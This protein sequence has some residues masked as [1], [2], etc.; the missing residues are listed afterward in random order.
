M[1]MNKGIS[2]ICVFVLFF[3]FTACKN[4]PA[5]GYTIVEGE[6]DEELYGRYLDIFE[7]DGIL[8]SIDN[9]DVAQEY[10]ILMDMS[11]YGMEYYSF[12]IY[13]D[14][15]GT[16]EYCY[17]QMNVEEV[18]N[19]ARGVFKIYNQCYEYLSPDE[20]AMLLDAIEKSGFRETEGNI[21]LYVEAM[22]GENLFVEG[23]DGARR[24]FV[25]QEQPEEDHSLKQLYLVFREFVFSIL[26]EPEE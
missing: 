24:Y 19:G 5:I 8:D 17:R 4:T 13:N 2:I 15:T 1:R 12:Q 23:N 11:T 10:R 22:D 7:V 25:Q 21:M 18:A 6:Y 16:I 14:K 20:T 26:E 3:T 9:P